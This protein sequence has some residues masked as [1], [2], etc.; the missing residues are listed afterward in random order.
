[1]I[2]AVLFIVFLMPICATV[3]GF[4]VWVSNRNQLAED[5]D[6][7][8]EF[9]LILVVCL[10]LAWGTSTTDTARMYLDPQFRLQTELDANPVYATIKQFSPDDH[11]KLHDF[12]VLQMSEGKTLPEAL[13]QAR[14]LLVELANY[15]LGFSD[16][17]THLL[18]AQVTVDT[19]KELQAQDPALCYQA[20][21]IK[22]PLDQKILAEAFSAENTSAFQQAIVALYESADRGMRHERPPTDKPVE[23]NAA[24]LEYRVVQKI[25]EEQF[26]ESVERQLSQ[27]S[28]PESPLEPREQMCA[29]K[30]VQLEAMLE[31]Q[32]AMAARLL[33]SV[34]R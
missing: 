10:L 1:M 2:V 8:R 28:F 23:F 17:K 25:V 12:L 21:P 22:Q 32:Q 5:R 3:A 9:V 6:L 30:I 11:K 34:L 31:R 27:K 26:G 16:Q 24:A 33:D 29:A 18:W 13:L 14:T 7:L 15:R 20:L 19:L 4:L